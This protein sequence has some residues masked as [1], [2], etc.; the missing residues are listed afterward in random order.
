MV[1]HNDQQVCLLPLAD[2]EKLQSPVFLWMNSVLSTNYA[3]RI[4][5]VLKTSTAE[6][7]YS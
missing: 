6:I 1:T 4:C 7:K 2:A 3:E 5:C